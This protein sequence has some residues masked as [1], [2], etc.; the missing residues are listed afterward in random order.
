M[1]NTDKMANEL[2]GTNNMSVAAR[3]PGAENQTE[4]GWNVGEITFY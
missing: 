1:S 4:T 3:L 2:F